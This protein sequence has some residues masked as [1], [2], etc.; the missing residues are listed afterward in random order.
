MV[1]PDTDEPVRPNEEGEICVRTPRQRMLCYW[2]RPKETAETVMPDGFVRTG[3]VGKYN[4]KG[5][6]IVSTF[7]T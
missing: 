7:L 2:G 3:D 5:E 6:V 1:H 4:E